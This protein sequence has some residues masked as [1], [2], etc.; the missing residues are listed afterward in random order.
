MTEEKYIYGVRPSPEYQKVFDRYNKRYF[1]G[2][3]PPTIVSTALLLKLE[4]GPEKKSH[5]AYAYLANVGKQEYIILDRGTSIFHPI[6]TH[7]SI[8]HESIHLHLWP[9]KWHGEKYKDEVRRIAALG[10]FDELI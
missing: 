4:S 2:E 8:L 1:Y 6:L 9:Y 5:G 7:Q 3:L 10:A